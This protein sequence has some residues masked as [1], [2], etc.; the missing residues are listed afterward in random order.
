M[1]VRENNR[2]R[3][4]NI[5]T[6]AMYLYLPAFAILMLLVSIFGY[7]YFLHHRQITINEKSEELSAVS[8]LKAS[9]I[10]QW[11]KDC[12][13]NAALTYSNKLISHRINDYLKGIDTSVTMDEMHTWLETIQKSGGYHHVSLYKPDG[14]KIL[15]V[16]ANG[17]PDSSD[18]EQIITA[19]ATQKLV[20][21]D[22]HAGETSRAP[23]LDLIIP[24]RYFEGKRSHCIAILYFEIDPRT[25]LF[26]LIQAWPT[27]STTAETLLVKRDGNDVVY[28]S[29]LR[30][31]KNNGFIMRKPL[32]DTD[33]AAS[34]AILGHEVVFEGKDY[35][36]VAVL[37]ATRSIPDSPWFI[38]AKI[39]TDEIIGPVKTRAWYVFSGA[40]LLVTSTGLALYLWWVRKREGYLRREYDA[41]IK[42]SVEQAKNQAELR[43][44]HD[45]LE[46]MVEQ[47]TKELQE[48]KKRFKLLVESVT[49]YIYSVTIENGQITSTTHGPGCVSVTGYTP[50]EFCANP[51]LWQSIIHEEDRGIVAQ[52]V[53]SIWTDDIP[54]CIEYRLHHKD[55]TLRWLHD[56]LVPKYDQQGELVAYDGLVTDITE[57]RAAEEIIRLSND[58][59]ENLVVRRTGEL[60]QTNI[61][62]NLLKQIAS[63]ANTA[64]TSSDA[65]HTALEIIATVQGWQLGHVL[66]LDSSS[67]QAIDSK[68]WWS[69][70]PER[71]RPFMEASKRICFERGV[72][73]PGRT[74][75]SGQP[76]WIEDVVTDPNFPRSASAAECR[77]HGAFAFPVTA[78][79]KLVAVMEFFSEQPAQADISSMHLI[80]QTGIQLGVM[81]ER[82]R[83]EEW[84]LK[85]FRAVE[86]S[87]ASVVI[88]SKNGLIEYVNR[89]FTEISGYSAEE[90]IGRNP[91]MLN[92][93]LQPKE[94]YRKMWNMLFS[95]NEWRGDLRNRKKNGDIH[96]EHVLISPIRDENGEITH[97]VAVKDD[98]TERKRIAE[99]LQ[100][101]M[102]AADAANRSK[103]EFLANMSHEIRTPLNAIIGFSS[104]ALNADLPPRLR[105]YISKISNAGVSLLDIINEILDFSKIEAGKLKMEQ[106]LFNLDET[107]VNSI[108]VIQQK[109]IEKKLEL[110]LDVAPEVPLQ[111]IGDPLRLNQILTNL[112]GNAVKFTPQGE[113]E[114]TITVQKQFA[115]S[116]ILLF[117]VRDTGIGLTPEQQAALFQ[118]FTQADGST[119]RH[120]G[121]TGLGLSI[122]HRLVGM[123]GGDIW[124]KSE[125]GVGSTF[126]FTA[127]FRLAAEELQHYLP[128]AINGLRILVADDNRTSRNVLLKRLS[129]L[130]VTVDAVKNG[131]EAVATVKQQDAGGAP[132]GVILMDWQM[133]EIN[134][135]KATRQIKSDS[136][137]STVPAIIMISSFGGEAEQDE[138]YLAGADDFLRKPLTTSMLFDTLVKVLT[139]A[140]TPHD[141]STVL[142]T[143]T[144]SNFK[145]VRILLVEDNDINRQLAMELL[146][147]EGVS[148]DTAV[149][150]RE[151]VAMVTGGERTYDIV[152]M[153]VQMPVMDG[154]EATRLIRSDD[155]F[156]SLPIIATTAY[157][158]D[159]ERQKTI[160]AG[161]NA[162][163]SKPIDA[164]TMFTTIGRF[165]K[166]P[167]QETEQM[168]LQPPNPEGET[169]FPAITGLNITAALQ[170]IDGKKK[171]Y[172][173]MLQRFLN[174]HADTAESIAT[175]LHAD[176]RELA[177]RL[178]HSLKGV[179]GN[180]GAVP[181]EQAAAA[182]EQAIHRNQTQDAIG[183]KLQKF[184][185]ELESLVTALR[186][187]FPEPAVQET[188]EDHSGVNLSIV[189]PIL[190]RLFHYIRESDGKAEDYLSS[191]RSELT[192]LP[193]EAM[194]QL[195]SNLAHFDYDAALTTLTAIANQTGVNLSSEV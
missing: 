6:P 129:A 106:L 34:Q 122:S 28:L 110:H 111:L 24:I 16:P 188:P 78:R 69:N 23:H 92:S 68:I 1:E 64:Q 76:H 192:G 55:G 52:E 3:T 113:I 190:K 153:D 125:P 186:H 123:M 32:S 151:A 135:I 33:Q 195:A 50:E 175:A 47:R 191:C 51:L 164:H 193:R 97:F 7:G 85:L 184:T 114:V 9:Q 137:L 30:H 79:G 159:N 147:Q 65:L 139:P 183:E 132:Y 158:L 101:A 12:L 105:D 96:W 140:E 5:I 168:V 108:S 143:A 169:D 174:D 150:G 126:S 22:F 57:R 37:S 60:E 154:I 84:L 160:A 25:F 109:A 130:P 144:S 173:W 182:L 46:L 67:E 152:L 41:E 100:V 121:G 88:T 156:V 74:L 112:I 95:G 187:A 89:K 145:G 80:E 56:T 83:A 148:V 161:M 4:P 59:L 166:H 90:A 44:A 63:E 194:Q 170:R 11:R 26:P 19:A 162:H 176:N 185:E 134:G 18:R 43:K 117:S 91:R 66:E 157:A 180:M 31:R 14:E 142:H 39:D 27:Q 77:L 136:S 86:N 94:L 17:Q 70:N 104:L 54:P 45:G 36:G 133:P 75:A 163:I 40:L 119:T 2:S 61:E 177:E 172:F 155:R 73:L 179:A 8:D 98:I 38:V 42:L 116:I 29:N 99:E 103:S 149:N 167:T 138:A 81:I 128:E 82:F 49:N 20:F 178:A 15:S 141:S 131:K 102:E 107:L 58:E 53:A 171:L 72:G 87:P 93:G 120:F 146:E 189:A 48:S 13:N 165:L 10:S 124:V 21:N 71:Y 118:P 181:L 127:S 115:D 62:L 35:R